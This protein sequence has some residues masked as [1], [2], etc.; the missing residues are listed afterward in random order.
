MIKRKAIQPRESA[1]CYGNTTLKDVWEPLNICRKIDIQST[2]I[3]L[4][5]K[6]VKE[7]PP[8]PDYKK[9]YILSYIR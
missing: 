8:I 7:H 3:V 6:V 4:L 5:W 1:S 2:Y 9:T